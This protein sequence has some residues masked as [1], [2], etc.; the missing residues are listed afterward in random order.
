MDYFN[1]LQVPRRPW[2]NLEELKGSFLS[3]SAAL[4][5]DHL[6]P[7]SDADKEAAGQRYAELNAAYQC[8]R[9]PRDRLNHLLELERGQKPRGID[10]VPGATMDLFIRVEAVCRGTDGFVAEGGK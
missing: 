6:E 1:L 8:L 10:R 7:V 3:L 9:E 4:H 5:P 2:L